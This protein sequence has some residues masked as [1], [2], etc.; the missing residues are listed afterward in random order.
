MWEPVTEAGWDDGAGST[1]RN[2]ELVDLDG[3]GRPEV[4]ALGKVGPSPH[5]VKARL[6][7]LDLR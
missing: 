5:D 1:V 6:A 4:I 7:I 3:D 2:V